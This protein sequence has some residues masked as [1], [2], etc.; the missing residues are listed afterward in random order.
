MAEE[1]G[2]YRL[3]VSPDLP[4][5][6]LTPEGR[7]RALRFNRTDSTRLT[8]KPNVSELKQEIQLDEHR[9]P[10][11]ILIGQL[12][13]DPELGLTPEQAHELLLKDGPN[14][15]TSTKNVSTMSRLARNL[16]GG[17]CLLLWIGGFIS[18]IAFILRVRAG[19]S[20][21]DDN[22]IICIVLVLV[23]LL[24]GSFSFYQD[25]KSAK[26]MD[27]FR[28][29]VPQ[30][31]TVVRNGQKYN[32]P[33]EEVVVGDLIEIRSGDRIPADLRIISSQGCKVDNSNL[34]GES[35]PQLRSYE[36][37]SD[38][39]LATANLAFFSTYCVE[40][41]SRGLVIYTGDRTVM[42]RIASLASGLELTETPIAKEVDRFIRL[43]TGISIIIGS[44]LFMF[45]FFMGYLWFDAFMLLIGIIVANVPEGLLV[46]VTICLTL[47]AKRMVSKNCLIKN[48]E[49]VET[50]GSVSIICSDKTGTLTQNRMT[51]SHMWFDNQ[52]VEADTTEEQNG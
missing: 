26:L 48:L 47:T 46:T 10:L 42:G 12:Q 41:I 18:L 8:E 31:A 6:G 28:K 36:L 16:F 35:E 49:A 43:M 52:V 9:L 22:L 1:T 7:P 21:P 40:G 15:L 32:I 13:T 50:L 25:S 3:A 27:A 2:S 14:I 38:N 29:M 17:F 11:D 23:V 39:P 30:T 51:I 37:T 5:D 33:V 34:T 19:Q 45:A 20:S 44:I 4:D 24:I